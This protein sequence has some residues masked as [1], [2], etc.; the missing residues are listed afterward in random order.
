MIYLAGCLN[1]TG[2][3]SEYASLSRY[4]WLVVWRGGVRIYVIEQDI[5]FRIYFVL[6]IYL[7]GC[8]ARGRQLHGHHLVPSLNAVYSLLISDISSSYNLD[9][10]RFD[11]FFLLVYL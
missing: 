10:I 6:S 9:D 3:I 1:V 11:I 4:I 5:C 2:Y 7:A 8:L